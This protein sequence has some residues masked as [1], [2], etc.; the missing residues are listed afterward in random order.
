M[1]Q[2]FRDFFKSKFGLIFTIGFLI[3]IAILF[4]TP[5]NSIGSRIIGPILDAFTSLLLGI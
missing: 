2:F 5:G 4:L 3:L 1:L